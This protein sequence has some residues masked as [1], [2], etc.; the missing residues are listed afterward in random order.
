[1]TGPYPNHYRKR[2][3]A[4]VEIV[5]GR[6]AV[7]SDGL[8]DKDWQEG[9]D[10]PVVSYI[11]DLERLDG[12]WRLRLQWVDLDGTGHRIGPAMV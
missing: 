8:P 12:R 3:R 10:L 4:D 5:R 2:F 11:G 6:E 9:L 1:M 7:T